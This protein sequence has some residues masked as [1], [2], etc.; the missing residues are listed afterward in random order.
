MFPIPLLVLKDVHF[1][2]LI[3][4]VVTSQIKVK[5]SHTRAHEWKQTR[6]KNANYILT[7]ILQQSQYWNKTIE[8]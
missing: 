3:S 2:L 4:G 7:Q 1:V 6:D 5:L 8:T